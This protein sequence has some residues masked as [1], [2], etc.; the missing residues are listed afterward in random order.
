M[1]HGWEGFY[2]SMLRMQR[3][4]MMIQAGN[5]YTVRMTGT[6]PKNMRFAMHTQDSQEGSKILIPFPTTAAFTV[7]ANDVKVE[8]NPFDDQLG[9]PTELEKTVCG[10]NRYVGI[11][12]FLEFYITPGCEIRLKARDS[13]QSSVRMQWTLE[14]FYADDKVTDFI[15]RLASVLGIDPSRIYV[16]VV[17][18]GSVIINV[19]IFDENTDGDD[20]QA[21]W[22][23]GKQETMKKLETVL[24]DDDHTLLKADVLAV[25]VN[26]DVIVGDPIP[27][28]P[29]TEEFEFIDNTVDTDEETDRTQ[30][31]DPLNYSNMDKTKNSAGGTDNDEHIHGSQEDDYVVAFAGHDFVFAKNG[32][33]DILGYEGDD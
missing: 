7:F 33:D 29:D 30:I 8:P 12:N 18:E 9:R 20:N 25:E 10:E 27:P 4:P 17:Y 1:D 16:P 21:A 15:D 19:V 14:E 3:F 22:A 28:P 13:I 31:F 11:A 26:G 2:S 5:D 6:P 32:D 24:T 23:E